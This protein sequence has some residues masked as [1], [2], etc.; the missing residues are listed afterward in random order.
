MTEK[1]NDPVA[2]WQAMIGE[3]EKGFNAFAGRAMT[4]PFGKAGEATT[5][6][7][8]RLGDLME[9]YLVN[10]N[11]PS[12]SQMAGI[13]DRLQSIEGQLDEIKAQLAQAQKPAG[14]SEGGPKPSRSKRATPAGEEQR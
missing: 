1:R 12:R 5:G 14:A 8:Q 9:R 3:M 6:A 11:L 2:I 10:M 13:A 4:P 7:Q